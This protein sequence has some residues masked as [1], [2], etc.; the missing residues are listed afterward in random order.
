MKLVCEKNQSSVEAESERDILS[1]RENPSRSQLKLST[2]LQKICTGF[3]MRITVPLNS[4]V[5]NGRGVME[6]Q[7]S[8]I[9]K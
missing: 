5:K 7:R 9:V 1:A 2:C 3:A 8:H 6:E 4:T